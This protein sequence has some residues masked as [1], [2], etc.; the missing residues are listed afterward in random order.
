MEGGVCLGANAP[1]V[2]EH[3]IARRGYM[4]A[5]GGLRGKMYALALNRQRSVPRHGRADLSRHTSR[6]RERNAVHNYRQ[7]DYGSIK[8]HK[9]H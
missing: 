4:D 5:F 1:M 9:S 6:R 8:G 3:A 2:A 7:A